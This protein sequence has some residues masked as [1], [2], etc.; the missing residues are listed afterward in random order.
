MLL[1]SFSV[2]KASHREF[3]FEIAGVQGK[4]SFIT[5]EPPIVKKVD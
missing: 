3:H 4:F 2:A 1:E 5:V